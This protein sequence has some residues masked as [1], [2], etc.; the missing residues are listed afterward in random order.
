[1]T[2]PIEQYDEVRWIAKHL[3]HPPFQKAR[4]QRAKLQ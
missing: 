2:L 1:M 4:R 3:C